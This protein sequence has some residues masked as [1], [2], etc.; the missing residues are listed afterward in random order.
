MAINTNLYQFK[1]KVTA[2]QPYG[3]GLALSSEQILY[4]RLDTKLDVASL[5]ARI[6]DAAEIAM[7][8]PEQASAGALSP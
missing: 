4:V 8:K 5:V 6:H 7:A 1:I 2:A 3:D